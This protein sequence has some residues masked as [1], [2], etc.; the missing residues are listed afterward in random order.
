MAPNYVDGLIVAGY[1]L[2]Y[3]LD[4]MVQVKEDFCENGVNAH[5]EFRIILRQRE[6]YVLGQLLNWAKE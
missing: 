2:P 6:A 5:Y 1:L 4:A 3:A